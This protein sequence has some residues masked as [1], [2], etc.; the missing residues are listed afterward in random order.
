LED[1]LRTREGVG[2]VV[3]A[4]GLSTRMGQPKQ[5][6][7]WDG[8][9]MVRR[10]V[11]VLAASSVETSAIVVVVGHMRDEVVEALS[12]APTKIAFNPGYADG[13]MLRSL[14]AGLAALQLPEED[15]GISLGAALVALGDQ[16]QITVEVVEAVIAAWRAGAGKV[17]APSH[18]GRRGNPVL[19]DREM[20]PEIL[21]APPVG[22]PRDLLGKFEGQVGL[23]ETADDSILRDIDTPEDYRQELARRV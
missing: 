10:V 21:S 14:Q 7:V 18:H 17:V 4:A 19:F 2:A 8:Q 12:G 3:L 1:H 11:D 5:L 15:A 20:W 22:S 23:V 9:P 13:S 16:P 6:M